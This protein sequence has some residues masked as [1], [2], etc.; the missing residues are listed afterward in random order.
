MLATWTKIL[1]F[2][3]VKWL[4][5]RCETVT[6]YGTEYYNPYKDTLIKKKIN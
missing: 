1:P 2:F 3:I 5:R 6:Y 4:S